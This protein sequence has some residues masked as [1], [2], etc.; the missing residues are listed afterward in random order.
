MG[1]TLEE[2]GAT[3]QGNPEQRDHKLHAAINDNDDQAH[4]LN[5]SMTKKA[6]KSFDN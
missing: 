6:G 5:E 1:E 3:L 2:G 4:A